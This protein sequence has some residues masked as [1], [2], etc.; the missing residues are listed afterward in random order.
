VATR[1]GFLV[2]RAATVLILSGDGTKL[3]VTGV[4]DAIQVVDPESLEVK[5]T[6]QL[7]RDLMAN[8]LPLPAR[9][10]ASVATRMLSS[11]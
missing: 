6:I 2:G 8:P 11:P 4:G 7:G 3:F 5:R 10:R 9:I 1:K